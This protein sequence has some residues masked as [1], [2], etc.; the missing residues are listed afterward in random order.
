[1]PV[2]P[3]TPIGTVQARGL[4]SERLS[5][6]PA[7]VIG[8]DPSVQAGERFARAL[9]AAGDVALQTAT[10][11][12][13]ENNEHEARRMD[14]ELAATIRTT[15]YGDGTDQNPGYFATRG[16]AAVDQFPNIQKNLD[17]ARKKIAGRSTNPRIQEM[18]DGVAE[19]RMATTLG[20]MDRFLLKE[21]HT[22]MLTTHEARKAEFMDSA[23]SAWNDPIAVDK[24]TNNVIQETK[25]FW[26]E[27]MGAGD[28]VVI[29]KVEEAVTALNVLVI[30]R[31]LAQKDVEGAKAFYENR[32]NLI[33]GR[34]RPDIEAKLN[35][36]DTQ[37]MT[38]LRKKVKNS[39][40]AENRGHKDPEFLETYAKVSSLADGG[41]EAAMVLLEDLDQATA[42]S[43]SIRSDNQRSFAS[44]QADINSTPFEVS[45][46]DAV[47]KDKRQA[48]LQR[49][50]TQVAAGNGLTMAAENG[51]IEH[52]APIRYGAAES[53]QDRGT[54][55]E[56]ASRRYGAYIGPLNKQELTNFSDSLEGKSVGG[57]IVPVASAVQMIKAAVEGLGEDEVSG[58]VFD[59]IQDNPEAGMA[60][61]IAVDRQ[62][63]AGQ[64]IAG[65]RFMRD[66]PDVKLEQKNRLN[67]ANAVLGNMFDADTASA[68]RSILA[69]ADALYA[70]RQSSGKLKSDPSAYE[71]AINDVVGGMLTYNGR[72]MMA[73]IPGFNDDQWRDM[74][75]V[76]QP[77][78]L[79][80][81]SADRSVPSRLDRT[82]IPLEELRQYQF[83]SSGFGTYV[84][85][86]NNRMAVSDKTGKAWHFDARDYLKSGRSA[87]ALR[88]AGEKRRTKVLQE[89][90]RQSRPT[91]GV[92]SI[93]LTPEQARERLQR[94]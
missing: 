40:D 35:R 91:E 80:D 88:A 12:Q 53:W 93:G 69:A 73:P 50:R 61:A 17:E 70:Y 4:S 86:L 68:R 10:K 3:T 67:S 58:L 31:F 49:M 44:T 82:P 63:M 85:V 90:R 20:S 26:T 34:V 54:K 81:F 76:L 46:P 32:K 11:I 33:D 74:I 57:S 8:N 13:I 87:S 18:F 37:S 71:Q 51:V 55:S 7:Q 72:N 79:K 94:R 83:V 19:S 52:P 22:A 42:L 16:Q 41:N 5:D 56:I 27:V 66:N 77:N 6:A 89:R 84:A 21:R 29:G 9:G 65:G 47:N 78:D 45:G 28:D 2:V 1:M 39:V 62:E 92:P 75:G 25:T 36:A 43:A 59:M 38:L 64:I 14:V 60:V 24:N 48:N 30:D 23:A 15:L